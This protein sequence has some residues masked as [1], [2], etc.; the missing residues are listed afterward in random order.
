MRAAA[1]AIVLLVVAGPNA[2]LAADLGPRAGLA[3]AAAALA[4]E[5]GPPPDGRRALSL[6]VEPAGPLG[7]PLEA[8]LE[9]ALARLGYAVTPRDRAAPDPEA[10]ARDAGQDWLV[11]A[12]AAVVPGRREL[13]LSA[14]VIATWPSF[15]L[16]RRPAARAVPPRLVQLR[17]P[18]DAETLA[19]ARAARGAPAPL[20]V[21]RFA[22]LPGRVLALG[23]GDVPDAGGP[24]V[25][26]ALS[27]AVI[28][29]S[30]RG[31]PVARGEVDPGARAPVRDPAAA[32]AVGDFGAARI[33][34][35]W[36]GAPA[37]ETF[38]VRGG[39]LEPVARLAAAPLCA[40]GAGTVFGRFASGTGVLTDALAPRPED[41]RD[42]SDRALYAVACAPGGGPVAFAM[43][44]TDL[45]ASLLGPDR[46]RAAEGAP[47]LPPV[48]AGVAL[49]D[50]DGDGVAEVVASA[51]VTAPPDRVSVLAA[52]AGAAAPLLVFEPIAGL[53]VAGAG[54]DLTGDG[55][56][57]AL[58]ASVA[59]EADGSERTVL[60]LV[61][62]DP[63]GA[64]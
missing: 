8:A 23:I 12:R 51:P 62:S 25:V 21:R 33:A 4:A 46:K 61:T 60:L 59:R 3:E 2:S 58:L 32:V 36:A 30:A 52:R 48:G 47:A 54:G 15:F 40:G 41:A 18:A 9:A 28:V 35:A 44:G 11:R 31:A 17:A 22:E 13:A 38:A 7:G 39:R 16:Q 56:D 49:A 37:G 29:L 1:A 45:R 43:V 20:V 26:A 55:I 27:D 64:P 6:D 53:V 10:A 50:L 24:A 34:V 42:R 14:E 5:I 19:L 63:G 57:D